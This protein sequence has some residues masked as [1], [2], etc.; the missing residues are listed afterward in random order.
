MRAV[1]YRQVWS[2]LEGDGDLDALRARG[3]AATR[4]LAKRQYTWLNRWSH[5]HRL[6]PGPAGDAKN[7]DVQKM[8]GIASPDSP[9]PWGAWGGSGELFWGHFGVS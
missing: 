4:S 6:A 7:P 5:V 3:A 1:G 2:Y 8:L 9:R